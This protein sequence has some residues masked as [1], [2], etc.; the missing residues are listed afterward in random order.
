MQS[1]GYLFGVSSREEGTELTASLA[2]EA[3]APPAC[4]DCEWDD[5]ADV[6]FYLLVWRQARIAR[7]SF[8][9][10]LRHRTRRSRASD[11]GV[12]GPGFDWEKA[13]SIGWSLDQVC[14]RKGVGFMH[15]DNAP[16]V[17]LEL[18]PR[19]AAR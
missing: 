10:V 8:A 3:S 1:Y 4:L 5:L 16:A 19:S 15:A 18:C 13:R 6:K 7:E 12:R 17:A 2:F 9:E 14:T 11:A